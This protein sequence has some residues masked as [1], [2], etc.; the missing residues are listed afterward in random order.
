[1][2][3]LD[4]SIYGGDMP[5]FLLSR[6]TAVLALQWTR[7]NDPVIKSALDSIDDS[8]LL[9]VAEFKDWSLATVVRCLLYLWLGYPDECRSYAQ[10]APE[11]EAALLMSLCARQGG[12]FAA[13]KATLSQIGEHEIYATLA[14]HVLTKVS[15]TDDAAVKRFCDIV[16]LGEQWEPHAFVDLYAQA[17]GGA[18]TAEGEDAVR[19][20]QCREFAVFLEYCY[21]GAGGR[22]NATVRTYSTEQQDLRRRRQQRR[23]HE[24]MLKRQRQQAAAARQKAAEQAAAPPETAGKVGVRCPKCGKVAMVPETARGKTTTCDACGT[25]FRIPAKTAA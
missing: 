3:E 6:G 8:D 5:R 25:S 7:T 4:P 13:A 23:E 12:D 24:E 9:G 17:V 19:R 22:K 20:L 16:K 15:A 11:A 1:M 14:R 21:V 2:L 10:A 18:L